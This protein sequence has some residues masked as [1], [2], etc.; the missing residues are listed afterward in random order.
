MK[1]TYFFLSLTGISVFI[2]MQNWV[3]TWKFKW[4][5]TK[6][7]ATFKK[8]MICYV[9]LVL[10]PK[11]FPCMNHGLQQFND[12]YMMLQQARNSFQKAFLHGGLY[13]SFMGY[14]ETTQWQSSWKQDPA[15][16]GEKRLFVNEIT[17]H[18]FRVKDS[19][20]T[21]SS[22]WLDSFR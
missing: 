3:S 14:M 22:D 1:S 19:L 11:W 6:L 8:F 12:F 9:D 16:S 18:L 5:F 15:F 21:S 10:K 17:Q 7:I 20:Q 4:M 13:L 2:P